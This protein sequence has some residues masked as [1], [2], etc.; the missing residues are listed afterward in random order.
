M[1]D[2]G[3]GKDPSGGVAGV[4]ENGG[5][6]VGAVCEGEVMQVSY[7]STAKMYFVIIAHGQY[8]SSYSNMASVSVK[9]G[10]KVQ[11]NKQ[12]GTIASALDLSTGKTEYKLVFG[13]FSP[14]A[15]LNAYQA[16][17]R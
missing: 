14:T 15:T 10:D 7:N 1:G 8:A 11:A 12:I 3:G 5:A 6:E 2:G 17:K 13:V 4:V 16:L 9:K